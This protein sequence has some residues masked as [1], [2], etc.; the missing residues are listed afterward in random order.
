[1]QQRGTTTRL[2]WGRARAALRG[3]NLA[4]G[5][6][7]FDRDPGQDAVEPRR[8]CPVEGTARSQLLDEILGFLQAGIDRIQAGRPAPPE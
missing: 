6:R 3:P 8:Q 7:A 2:V 1:M 4:I 5:V